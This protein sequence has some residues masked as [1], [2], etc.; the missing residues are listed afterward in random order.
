M[1]I[2]SGEAIS[3]V[4]ILSPKLG[5]LANGIVVAGDKRLYWGAICFAYNS[6]TMFNQKLK[7]ESRSNLVLD[8]FRDFLNPRTKFRTKVRTSRKPAEQTTA[9]QEVLDPS[10]CQLTAAKGL[11]LNHFIDYVHPPMRLNKRRISLDTMAFLLC[12]GATGFDV[13]SS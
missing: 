11:A 8:W 2:N 9:T 12:Y 5:L 4:N 1:R 13:D 10:I 7:W 3:S 6:S